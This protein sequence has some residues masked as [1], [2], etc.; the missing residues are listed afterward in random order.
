MGYPR[1]AEYRRFHPGVVV[2]GKYRIERILAEG[3]MGQVYVA[4]QEPI[5]RKVALKVLHRSVAVHEDSVRRFFREAVAVSQLHHPNTVTILDYGEHDDGTLYLTMELLDGRDLGS[6]LQTHGAMSPEQVIS[7]GLQIASALEE[8]HHKGVLHRDLKPDNIILCNIKGHGEVAK[9]IDFGVAK[10]LDVPE[11][12]RVTREGFVCGTAEYMAPE[13]SAG[14]EIDGRTDL[15][16]LGCV[17]WE[18][19]MD[20]LPYKGQNGLATALK[21]QTE[22]IPRL[23]E[24]VPPALREFIYAAMAKHIDDRPLD[25]REFILELEAAALMSGL[26]PRVPPELLAA[27]SAPPMEPISFGTLALLDTDD[28]EVLGP[29]AGSPPEPAPKGISVGAVLVLLLCG[30]AALGLLAGVFLGDEQ[31]PEAVAGPVEKA[32]ARLVIDSEEPV[33]GIF[34]GDVL[35]GHTPHALEGPPGTGIA[36]TLRKE[37]F[38]DTSVE[39]RFPGSGEVRLKIHMEAVAPEQAFVHVLSEPVGAEVWRGGAQIGDTPHTFGLDRS[40][41][42][43]EVEL[44]AAGH[45]PRKVRISASHDG[46]SHQIQLDPMDKPAEVARKAAAPARAAPARA[47]IAQPPV[48]EAAP[49]PL[50]TSKKPAAAPS[51]Y[52]LVED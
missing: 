47:A 39:E 14:E 52:E 26:E 13:L 10:L 42:D 24:Q 45:V 25:A 3:G 48:R 27:A 21:H 18:L 9:V 43:F 38:E 40:A 20:R 33:V 29:P 32:T 30:G 51:P 5:G 4:I 46:I 44:R 49:E 36:L 15:Y 8:A 19:L 35:L 11:E 16:A 28:F 7:I 1:A 37:G 12:E 6:L 41:V 22:P 34:D 17:M 31:T 23:S 2:A 50:R